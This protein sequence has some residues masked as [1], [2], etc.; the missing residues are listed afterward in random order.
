MSS[1]GGNNESLVSTKRDILISEH[2]CKHGVTNI[3]DAPSNLLDAA[4]AYA[5]SI[6]GVGNDN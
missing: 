3:E 4:I 5:D 1:N 2:L 6:L